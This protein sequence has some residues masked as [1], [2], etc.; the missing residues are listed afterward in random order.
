ML[1]STDK[2][3]S[4]QSLIMDYHLKQTIQLKVAILMEGDKAVNEKMNFIVP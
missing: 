3:A 1:T 2:N 4:S